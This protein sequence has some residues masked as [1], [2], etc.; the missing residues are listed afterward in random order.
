MFYVKKEIGNDIEVK[1]DLYDDEIYTQCPI[2]GKEIQI[3]GEFLA[4]ILNDGD[5]VG[6]SIYCDKCTKK[7]RN[8]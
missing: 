5:L 1:I 6:T 4:K 2:C 8:L 3:D 7:R